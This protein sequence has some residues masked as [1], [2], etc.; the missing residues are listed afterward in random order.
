MGGMGRGSLVRACW[1]AAAFLSL[2]GAANALDPSEQ[3]GQAFVRANCARCHSVE[4]TGASPLA[5]A[6]PFRTLHRRYPVEDLAESLAEGIVTGHPTMP[7]FKL[8]PGRVRDLIA[9]LKTL[10]R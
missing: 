7:E 2:L 5:E 1:L 6:P 10:E 9:Y 3:R 4:K 8:D